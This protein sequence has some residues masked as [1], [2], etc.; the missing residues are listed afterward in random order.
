MSLKDSK[1][2]ESSDKSSDVEQFRLRNFITKLEELGELDI[3]DEAIQTADIAVRLEGNS[4]AVLFN[5]VGAEQ[6]DIVG[7]VMASRS[8]IAAA[9]GVEEADV[10]DEIRSRLKTP[11]T[12]VE[13]E[14]SK[15][16]HKHEL[17]I[18]DEADITQHPDT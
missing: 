11:Q 16:P 18:D 5:N 14:S 12:L 2:F 15:A 9:F 4:R 17:R 13:L 8:R 6:V 1:R 3:C 7:N 10:L